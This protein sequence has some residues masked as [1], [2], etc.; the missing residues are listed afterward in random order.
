M[1]DKWM[2]RYAQL[3]PIGISPVAPGTCASLVAIIA[4]PFAFL[5]LSL[6]WRLILLC[7]IYYTG[8]RCSDRAEKTLGEKDP[9][10]VVIDELFGQWLVILPFYGLMYWELAAAFVL[11]RIFD[12]YKPWPVSAAEKVPGGTGIMV[13]DAAAALYAMICLAG[14]RWIGMYNGWN[15]L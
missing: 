10:S 15:M 1:N 14:V 13:D 6:S 9:K 5:P 12:I 8:V 7:G 2:V 3:W 11:F 4:A